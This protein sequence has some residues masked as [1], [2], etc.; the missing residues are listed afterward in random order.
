M[1]RYS[2]TPESIVSI[3]VSVFLCLIAT[4]CRNTK[5]PHTYTIAFSQCVGNDLWRKTM[6]DEIKTELSLHPDVKFIYTD[7]RGSSSQQVLQVRKMLAQG[8]DLLIISPNEAQPLTTVV[9]ETFNKGIPVVVID[10]KTTSDSYTAYVGA[11]NYQVGKMAGDYFVSKTKGNINVIEITGS[12]GSSPAIDREKGFSDGIKPA[13]RI[14]ITGKLNGAWTQ[15]TAEAELFK[16]KD[17][18]G[19][20]N[21]IFAHNDVMA[22]GA[23]RVL[24][25]LKLTDSIFIM[26]VDALPGAGGGLEMIANKAINA[27][28]LYPTGG[29]EAVQTAFRILNNENIEKVNILQSLIID[30]TN[31]ELM[32]MQWDRIS[33]QQ[34]DIERQ[35]VLLEEQR[36]IYK[37]QATILNTVIITLV[38]VVVFGGLAFYFLVE[39]R[40]IN[41]SLEAKNEQILKQR[42][43]LIDMS[44]KAEI[45]TEAKLNFFTNI[46]HEFRTPL[47]LMLGPIDDLIQNAK[48]NQDEFGNL[49][50]AHKNILIL[51]KLVNQLIDYRKIEYDKQMIHASPNNIIDLI[52]EVIGNFKHIAHK[53]NIDLRLFT[54]EKECTIWFDLNMLDKVFF[55][56]ISNAFKFVSEG[57]RIYIHLHRYGNVV[58]IDVEDNGVGMSN[59]HA[60]HIF[61]HF[62]QADTGLA[63][64]SGLGLAL[65]K[66]IIHL[67]HGS[68]TVKSVKWQSTVFTIKLP[69]GDEHLS[70]EEKF[71]QL[72]DP[73]SISEQ[74]VH[75]FAELDITPVSVPAEAFQH[76]K[77]HSILIVE[78]N[79]DLLQ[80]LTAKL[81]ERYEIFTATNGAA[82]IN[83]AYE[84]VPDLII[85]DVVLPELSGKVLAERLKS[86]IRTS[87]IPII[88]LTAQSSLEHQIAGMKTMA[89]AYLTKPF[90]LPF[91]LETVTNLLN[92]RRILKDHY[93]SEIKTTERLPVSKTLDKKFINDFAGFIEQNLANEHLNVDDIAKAI[94]VSRIQLYRKV[95]ALLGCNITDYI[96]NRR[97]KKAKYLLTNE[98]H[99]ISMITYMVGFSTP[100]YFSTVF[101]AKYGCTPTEFRKQQKG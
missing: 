75:Y 99:T 12:P 70:K 17:Q 33:S 14:H 43:E 54:Q 69:L 61:E 60:T 11:D 37:D 63:K 1:F 80:F 88:L 93:T 8:I 92:N 42:N 85:S 67:H 52:S 56:L 100:N 38:L 9:E 101:K 27:S 10:R 58:Q 77:E 48:L 32:T 39:N 87:H 47:T 15:E 13:S 20:V 46:S 91:L 5:Q 22:A 65:T 49:K 29:K 76:P 3:L 73:K 81:S 71:E 68:I 24:K 18:L 45:A 55:N 51:M 40:K 6:L 62:Y 97:L 79:H 7:A 31:V 86:D 64:G 82:G 19:S 4:G 72:I 53:R 44:A 66:E 34:K 95:K 90:N 83:E 23:R 50:L 35:Q 78:D 59:E 2:R 21:A 84:S 94:G 57:G 74:A 36:K 28:A 41:R 98:D 30:S 16:I 89:D 25:E 96:M 26:G